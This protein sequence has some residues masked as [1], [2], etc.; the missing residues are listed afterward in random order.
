MSERMYEV[1]FAVEE[2]PDIECEAVTVEDGVVGGVTPRERA[3]VAA[4]GDSPFT[5]VETVAIR[6]VHNG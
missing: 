3:V 1:Q 5:H 4:A 6:E 2:H